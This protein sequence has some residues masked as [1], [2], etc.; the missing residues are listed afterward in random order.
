MKEEGGIIMTDDQKEFLKL[1][2]RCVIFPSIILG[3]GFFLLHL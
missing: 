1:I 2:L 3:F